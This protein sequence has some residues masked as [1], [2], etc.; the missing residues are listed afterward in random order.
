VVREHE[1]ASVG[2]AR[3]RQ[4]QPGGDGGVEGV[5]VMGQQDGELVRPAELRKRALHAGAEGRVGAIPVQS[6][7]L[8]AGPADAQ[9][10]GLVHQQRDARSLDFAHK[11]SPV[12][13][14][15]VVAHAHRQPAGRAGAHLLQRGRQSRQV[16]ESGVNQVAG[17][18]DQVG[19]QRVG[20][21]DNLGEIVHLEEPADV[22]VGHMGDAH[23]VQRLR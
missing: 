19:A 21:G 18:K 9:A 7:E 16:S 1:L 6:Q 22:G 17:E 11:L 10:Q 14:D 23:A 12:S 5:R 2:V 8:D 20:P 3:K 4:R 13:H 15:V